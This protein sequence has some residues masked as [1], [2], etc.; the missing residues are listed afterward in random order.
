MATLSQT[1]DQTR[2]DKIA[3]TCPTE[4]RKKIQPALFFLDAGEGNKYSFPHQRE[5]QRCCVKGREDL[6]ANERISLY[7]YCSK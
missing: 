7:T 1:L 3:P 4:N 6:E 5:M 2:P